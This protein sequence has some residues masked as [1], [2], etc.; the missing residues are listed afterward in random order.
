M[1]DELLVTLQII[2]TY[3]PKKCIRKNIA[4]SIAAQM[5]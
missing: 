5:Q 2:E 3:P 4:A 1:S